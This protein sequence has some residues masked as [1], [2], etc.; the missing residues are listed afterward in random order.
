[1][2][3]KLSI[4]KQDWKDVERVRVVQGTAGG[5]FCEQGNETST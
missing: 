3:L 2:I 1:M 4:N 5:G